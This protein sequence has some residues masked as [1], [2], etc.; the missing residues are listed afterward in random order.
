VIF[1]LAVTQNGS[2]DI[3]DRLDEV[4]VYK[5]YPAQAEAIYE[6]IS[7]SYPGS[8]YALT[9]H[10][11]LVLSYI[12]AKRES[13][14]KQCLEELAADFAGHPALASALY[15]IASD[16]ELRRNYDSARKLYE[17]IAQQYPDSPQAGKITLDLPKTDI[18]SNIEKKEYQQAEDAIT[19]FVNDFNDNSYLPDALYTIARRYERAK[20]YPEAEQLYNRIINDYPQDAA[21]DSCRLG[22]KKLGIYSVIESGGNY[23]AEIE[24]LLID[25][26]SCDDLSEALYDIAIRL[27]RESNYEQ[28][29]V[30]YRK[31]IEK[32]PQSSHAARAPL[33][34]SRIDILLMIDRGDDPNASVAVEKLV[35]DFSG[36]SYLSN[37][38]LETAKRYKKLGKYDDAERINKLAAQ[39]GYRSAFADYSKIRVAKINITKL[40]ESGQDTAAA[41]AIDKLMVDFNSID[42]TLL[43]KAVL[44]CA[45]Q[46]YAKGSRLQR[47]ASLLAAAKEFEKAIALGER[48]ISQLSPSSK[49]AAVHFFLAVIYYE[50]MADY[51]RALFYLQ[52][53]VEEWPDYEF[54]C[55]A[56]FL[57]AQS[58]AQLERTGHISKND[59]AE[60]IRQ[61]CRQ[62]FESYPDCTFIEQ[63]ERLLEIWSDN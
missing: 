11:N 2:A 28:A 59:A 32:F 55:Y 62:L 56:Q 21:C 20:K 51:E 13:D 31:I 29:K 17:Q 15:E 9:A 18:L 52:K 4:D 53:V 38:V 37:V 54:A 12:P 27:E 5:W 14:A 35:A 36:N 50:N 26:A 58:Y 1:L 7:D 34:I 44:E 42:R 33:D 43:A 47:E 23:A 25:F 40:I 63:T 61:A 60:A 57:I 49:D 24:K 30:I 41:A 45:E 8:D 46:Y 39:Q 19:A 6:Q 48:I 22:L 10:K 3:L 16:Y